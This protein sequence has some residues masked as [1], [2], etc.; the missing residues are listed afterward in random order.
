MRFLK[1]ASIKDISAQPQTKWIFRTEIDISSY[2]KEFELYLSHE[3]IV[4]NC[5]EDFYHLEESAL[6]EKIDQIVKGL[7]KVLLKTVLSS[8]QCMYRNRCFK[9]QEI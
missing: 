9:L 5:G 7:K 3:E 6:D 2:Y 1:K 8:L 4:K